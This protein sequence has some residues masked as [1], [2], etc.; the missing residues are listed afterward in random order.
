MNKKQNRFVLPTALL[1]GFATLFFLGGVTRELMARLGGALE[2]VACGMLLLMLWMII[3]CMVLPIKQYSNT[4][5]IIV[6]ALLPCSAV[7]GIIAIASLPLLEIFPLSTVI[8]IAGLGTMLFGLNSGIAYT[9]NSGVAKLNNYIGWT[10]GAVI[11]GISYQFCANTLMPEIFLLF[12]SAMLLG[13]TVFSKNLTHKVR[14]QFALYSILVLIISGWIWQQHNLF[15]QLNDN[16]ANLK[17]YEYPDG[18]YSVSTTPSQRR[19]EFTIYKNGLKLWDI[20]RDCGAYSASTLFAAM[21]NSSTDQQRVLLISSP[22]TNVPYLLFSLPNINSI[23][24]LCRNQD[25]AM[26]ATYNGILP[27]SSLRFKVIINRQQFFTRW[28]AQNNVKNGYDLIMV[29]DDNAE[30]LIR[31]HFFSQLKRLLNR[32]GVV[33]ISVKQ[34]SQ[35]VRKLIKELRNIFAEVKVM[36]GDPVL[37]AAGDSGITASPTEL[38]KRS[39]AKSSLPAGTLEALYSLFMASSNSSK[40]S[41]QAPA[42]IF[43]LPKISLNPYL[44]LLIIFLPYLILRFIMSRHHN[45]SIIFAAGE[46]GFYATAFM[47]IIAVYFQN[48]TGELYSRGTLLIAVTMYGIA[49]GALIFKHT[50]KISAWFISLSIILPAALLI[51]KLPVITQ[52]PIGFIIIPLLLCAGITIGCTHILLRRKTTLLNDNSLPLFEFI[53]GAIAIIITIFHEFFNVNGLFIVIALALLRAITASSI[54][55]IG[56]FT[57]KN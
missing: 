29:F 36:Y 14:L 37:I 4:A 42:K 34:P 51:L 23:D 15:C 28:V 56:K 11:G 8:I 16:S 40:M 13:I 54:I 3:G 53:G 24:L 44:L 30:P 35:Q 41:T 32:G 43:N 21:Q 25:F 49:F 57:H 52:W 7:I 45:N 2:A 55:K 12:C 48:S 1:N 38:D 47:L 46:N 6:T 31:P 22:F 18:R 50:P 20:P 19:G 10:S 39:A 33:T 26:L 17:S 5:R 9:L 27:A